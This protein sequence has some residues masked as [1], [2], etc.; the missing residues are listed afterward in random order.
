MLLDFVLE[1][2]LIAFCADLD[3][4][5]IYSYKKDIGSD[6]VLVEKRLEKNLS[7]MTNYSYEMLKSIS[8]KTQ[9]V[10]LTTRS[11]EQYLRI[12]FGSDVRIKY[13][14]VANGGILLEDGII[15]QTWYNQSKALCKEVVDE[16][17]SIR[18]FL[19]KRQEIYFDIRLVDELFL[20]TKSNNPS[21]TLSYLKETFKTDDFYIDNNK[22][23]IYVF[24]SILNKGSA[25]KRLKEYIK[26]SYVISAGDSEFDLYMQEYSDL[27]ILHKD[28]NFKANAYTNAVVQ[29]GDRVFSDFLFDFIKEHISKLEV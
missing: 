2:V 11:L 18:K 23:K 27:I 1:A 17:K 4:T 22:E 24:P 29:N 10:P 12:D 19:E 26:P 25:V 7:Y 13:A 20:F 6:K 21:I 15:N 5:L 14:L 3:N 16:I 9:F 8:L 28:L